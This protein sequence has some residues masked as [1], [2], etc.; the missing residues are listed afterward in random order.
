M[1]SLALT[2]RGHLVLTVT[3][4]A[5]PSALVRRLES[6]FGRGSGHE[7]IELGAGEVGPH[8]QQT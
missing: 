8:F 2:P 3:D 7:L 4:E 5:L 6:A 1:S